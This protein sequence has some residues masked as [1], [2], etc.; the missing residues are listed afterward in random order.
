MTISEH[1]T[2]QVTRLDLEHLSPQERE[3]LHAVRSLSMW[4]YIAKYRRE[5]LGQKEN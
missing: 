3:W 4:A 1:I 2:D 5:T